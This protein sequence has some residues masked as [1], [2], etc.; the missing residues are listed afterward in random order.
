MCAVTEPEL[1]DDAVAALVRSFAGALGCDLAAVCRPSA[2]GGIEL[3]ASWPP[4][5]TLATLAA[6]V[7]SGFLSRALAAQRTELEQLTVAEAAGA[8]G[9]PR[10]T[11]AAAAPVLGPDSRVGTLIA[12]F[13]C[14]PRDV[15]ATLWAVRSYSSLF[16]LALEG[17]PGLAPL[18]ELSAH[19]QLTGCLR[20]DE[21]LRALDHEINRC[22]RSRLRLSCL[23]IDLEDFKRV[24]EFGGLHH[25]NAVLAA[26]GRIL[27]QG[28]RNCD[29]VGRYGGDE[30]VVILPQTAESEAAALAHRLRAQIGAIGSG[31]LHQSVTAAF[32]VAEWA[33][34]QSGEELL[35]AAAEALSVA[36]RS[37]VGVQTHTELLQTRA[38]SAAGRFSRERR[39]LSR[40]RDLGHE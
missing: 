37:R 26:V 35:S 2:E 15:P 14:R 18:L 30:F 40:R 8:H 28:V 23:F 5:E 7:G 32:G 38:L 39:P 29:L 20:C 19:D 4:V 22:V 10:V 9:W 13:V 25:G 31:P 34:G 16:A 12:A 36:I 1:A 11:A 3:V 27:C 33:P 17:R 21:T 6:H 24:N